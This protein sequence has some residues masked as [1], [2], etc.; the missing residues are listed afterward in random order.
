MP[1][2]FPEP[3]HAAD[4]ERHFAGMITD[5]VTP[6]GLPPELDVQTERNYGGQWQ[7]TDRNTY[8]GA[9]DSPPGCRIVGTGRTQQDAIDDLLEGLG[10]IH[11]DQCGKWCDGVK[12]L[13]YDRHGAEADLCSTECYSAFDID[14]HSTLIDAAM[15]AAKAC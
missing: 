5:P 7:A 14:R 13:T 3:D 4:V 10:Y 1:R 15:D 12:A 11:C 6:P 2:R 9:P 8:D